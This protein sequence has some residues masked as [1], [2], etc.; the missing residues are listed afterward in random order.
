MKISASI[1]TFGGCLF[2]FITGCSSVDSQPVD[3]T[4]AA[5]RVG[6]AQAAAASQAKENNDVERLTQLWERRRQESLATD[7]PIGP[8]DV[9]EINVAGMEEIKVVS[10][11]VTG[12]GTISLPFVGVIDASGMTDKTLREEIRRRLETNYMRNP[13]ISLFVKEFRSR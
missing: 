10:Q 12:E 13:Q 1:W 4:N 6:I 9:I 5:N 3:K 8:G 7:Y 11:R 2:L